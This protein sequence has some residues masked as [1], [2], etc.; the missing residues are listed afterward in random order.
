MT[1]L[2]YQWDD[3]GTARIYAALDA[4]SGPRRTA[5]ARRA[6]NHT[7]AKVHTIVKR[8]L[9][10][11]MG[12]TSQKLFKDG[13]VL[14]PI[15]ASG[16]HLEYQIVSTGRA[17]RLA[18]FGPNPS[19]PG[20]KSRSLSAAPW[21]NRRKFKRAFWIAGGAAWGRGNLKGSNI[22]M[23]IGKERFPVKALWG[24]NLN[25][26]LVKDATAAAFHATV[27]SSL[28]ARV[29]HE[30]RFITGGVFS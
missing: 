28:P 5:A 7:G 6:L 2:V 1:R 14:R 9:T 17:V 21:G 24:P 16:A 12:L 11:Q 22:Y 30:V 20:I 3:S 10:K 4:L 19:G 23:R 18:E 15:K 29:E 13:R 26:E 8:T 25:K 27:A